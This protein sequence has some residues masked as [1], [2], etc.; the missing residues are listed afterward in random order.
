M[1]TTIVVDVTQSECESLKLLHAIDTMIESILRVD[2]VRLFSILASHTKLEGCNYTSTKPEIINEVRSIIN[3]APVAQK[4][5]IG[6]TRSMLKGESIILN[7]FDNDD[8]QTHVLIVIYQKKKDVVEEY[9]PIR[10][11]TGCDLVL[12]VSH[13]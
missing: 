10:S 3:K 12:G 13:C 7:H 2:P 5:L 6:P 9:N 1:T 11:T 8:T 4:H